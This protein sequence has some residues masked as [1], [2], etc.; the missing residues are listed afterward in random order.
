VIAEGDH[1]V[2]ERL[3]KKL[4]HGPLLA[5]VEHVSASWTSP[6]HTYTSFKISYDK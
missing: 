2:L 4:H 6:T 1:M 3:L 5:R